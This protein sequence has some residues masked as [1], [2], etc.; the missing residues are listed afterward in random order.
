MEIRAWSCRLGVGLVLGQAAQQPVQVDTGQP[1]VGSAK[2]SRMPPTIPESTKVSLGQR[3][4][5]RQQARWPALAR[6]RTRFRGRFAYVDG[7][8][9]DGEVLSLCRLRY[10]GS[11]S[12]WGFAVYLATP[13]TP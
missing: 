3:L 8:L 2:I 12:L 6:V 10:G 4:R 1:Q 11:A 13:R 7:E 9:P 5:D